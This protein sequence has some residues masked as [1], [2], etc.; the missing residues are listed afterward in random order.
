MSCCS[1][2]TDESKNQH[3]LHFL[4]F[5]GILGYD[6]LVLVDLLTS[7]ETNFLTYLLKY[8]KYLIKTWEG[9]K[10]VI[11]KHWKQMITNGSSDEESVETDVIPEVEKE[12]DVNES[13]IENV[14]EEHGIIGA[15]RKSALPSSDVTYGRVVN[16]D[17]SD[18]SRTEN[19]DS[20]SILAY[21]SLNMIADAY[22]NGSSESDDDNGIAVSEE[23]LNPDM[24]KNVGSES[25]CATLG[26]EIDELDW[27][28]IETGENDV[29]RNEERKECMPAAEG[30]FD[31]CF[32]KSEE[33][34]KLIN[35]A[36]SKCT[37]Q[38]LV[39]DRTVDCIL[40]KVM[41]MLIRT[42]MKVEKLNQSGLMK[43]N[44]AVLVNLIASVEDIYEGVQSLS[45]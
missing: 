25:N 28:L 18:V 39:C 22:D 1:F 14:L 43:Y 15:K 44:P 2:L 8:L 33:H 31:E 5:V 27:K 4:Q 21:S 24:G 34:D 26:Q 23:M 13:V 6:H 42:R 9:F 20:K 40:D 35:A 32:K 12:K 36:D 11:L 30:N 3:H 37:N 45:R 38:S 17:L 16:K 41:G 19:E 10:L 29:E 7:P